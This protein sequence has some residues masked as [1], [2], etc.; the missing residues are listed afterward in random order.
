MYYVYEG[1]RKDVYGGVLE[2][3]NWR[4]L[5]ETK[6]LILLLLLSRLCSFKLLNLLMITSKIKPF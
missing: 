1:G 5:N 2:K 6:K 4:W 3:K